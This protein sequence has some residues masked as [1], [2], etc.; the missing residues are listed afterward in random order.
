MKK[1]IFSILS[2]ISMQQLMAQGI[3]VT[4]WIRNTTGI[5]ARHYVSGSSTPIN[6]TAHVNVQVVSYST[7][8]V[9]VK[10]SGLPAYIIGPYLDGNPSQGTN[11]AWIF[12]IPRTPVPATTFTAVGMG[13]IGVFLNGV[14]MYNYAD[15]RSYNNL[16]VWNRDAI[17]FEKTGFDC[18]K[19][20]PSP[21]FAGG[22]GG[23]L[24]G[25]S[26]HHHQNPS[27]FRLD[28]VVISNV[29][30]LYLA[31]GLYVMDS[32]RHSPLLGYAFDG[33]PIYGAYGYANADGTGG[34]KRIRSSYRKRAITTRTTLPDG[35][36]ASS[37]GPA[38]D[39]AFPLGCF[40]EDYTFVTGS[41][42][43]D[44]HN[45]RFA[46]TPEY[47]TGTYAYYT[48][49]DS[50][51]NSEYPYII[52]PTYYGVKNGNT[53]TTITETT[54]DY[55]PTAVAQVDVQSL[56]INIYPN[57][58]SDLV[59]IQIEKILWSDIDVQVYDLTGKLVRN[60]KIFAGSTICHLDTRTL[61][62]GEYIVYLKNGQQ[63][64]AKK[65]VVT[66]D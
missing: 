19:G 46:V 37:A 65:I 9:Y 51:Q 64:I 41:G 26:Y 53:V 59:A 15:G 40:K 4:S 58:A 45:G 1:L 44:V 23:P 34:I 16:G 2:L 21:V 6:D 61:Y 54:T 24:I 38:V 39:S 48:T 22:M 63:S 14:P 36:T 5:T 18:A 32:T 7:G 49:V 42:E 17:Y 33:Y 13:S 60:T 66:K 3:E 29:C 20:H 47:P 35:S 11:N 12:K 31:D 43:L 62:S 8:N 57:P 30:N 56:A 10:A 28:K 25:G 52:G 50:N 27:A 55:N